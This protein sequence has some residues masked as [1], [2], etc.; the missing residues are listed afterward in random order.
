MFCDECNIEFDAE[1]ARCPFCGGPLSRLHDEDDD[2]P[3]E[4]EE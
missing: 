2:Q 3:S 4:Q 1:L